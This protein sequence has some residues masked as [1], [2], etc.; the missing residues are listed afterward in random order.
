LAT[1]AAAPHLEH[2]DDHLVERFQAGDMHALDVLLLRYRRFARAK[3]RNYFLAGA[4]ADDLEQEGLIGLYKAARDYRPDREASFASF[5]DLCITRQIISAVK[6][7]TRH[8]HQPLNA[9]VSISQP[10]SASDESGDPRDDLLRDHLVRDPADDIVDGD[11]F[12]AVQTAI[13]QLLS[14]LEVEVLR[15]YVEGATYAEISQSLN[16]HTKA[17]DNAIQ[18]IKRKVEGVLRQRATA[19]ANAALLAS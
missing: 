12:E 5:A 11:Q 18:R 7:A 15:L 19:E 4:D 3:V 1:E 8:K 6:A 10:A 14:T 2:S 16:R 17:V 13:A 9:Y